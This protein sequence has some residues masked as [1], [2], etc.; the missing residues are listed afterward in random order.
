MTIQPGW[1]Y[2]VVTGI[3]SCEKAG[4]ELHRLILIRKGQDIQAV[5]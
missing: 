3:S 1:D 4:D 5:E 2:V